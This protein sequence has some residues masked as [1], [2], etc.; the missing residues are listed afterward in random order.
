MAALTA[1]ATRSTRQA[2]AS[3]LGL[4]RCRSVVMSPDRP[5][6][7]LSVKKI[8]PSAGLEFFAPLMNELSLKRIECGRVFVYCQK[9]SICADLYLAFMHHLGTLAYWPDGTDHVSDNRLVGMYHSGTPE[10]NKEVILKSL[11][12]PRGVCR[13]LFTTSAVGMGVDVKGLHLVVHWGPPT[14]AEQ[15][16]QEIGRA[17]RD[18]VESRAVLIYNGRQLRLCDQAMLKYTKAPMGCGCRRAMLLSAFDEHV[19]YEYHPMHN[20]CDL[21]AS[22]CPCSLD[23]GDLFSL[24]TVLRS[25]TDSKSEEKKELSVTSGQKMLAD[26]RLQ[27]L[28]ETPVF[29]NTSRSIVK[30]VLTNLSV[31]ASVDD[32]MLKVDVENFAQAQKIFDVLSDIFPDLK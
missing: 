13:V 30:Q 10:Y 4:K 15:Y 12:D 19:R 1:T 18:N 3:K 32:I 5:N 31:L 28:F 21:C 24:P 7:R 16:M 27:E 6:I 8:S 22:Q 25:M 20:C 9:I 17:G 29:E 2:I 26:V 23:H 11:E 14:N